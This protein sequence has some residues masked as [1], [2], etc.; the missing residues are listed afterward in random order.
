[1]EAWFGFHSHLWFGFSE[2]LGLV[3]SLD[4]LPNNS[5]MVGCPPS[6]RFHFPLWFGFPILVWFGGAEGFDFSLY[7]GSPPLFTDLLPPCMFNFMVFGGLAGFCGPSGGFSLVS[8]GVGLGWSFLTLTSF[9]PLSWSCC[10][11][12]GLVWPRGSLGSWGCG[13]FVTG[14]LG[15]GG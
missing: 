10:I 8:G 3:S 14:A 13:L 15:T 12:T 1:M 11:F 2:G 5:A 9:G 7:R 4:F 6:F